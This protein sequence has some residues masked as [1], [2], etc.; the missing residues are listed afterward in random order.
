LQA[1]ALLHSEVTRQAQR[2]E[3]AT[4]RSSPVGAEER[5]RLGANGA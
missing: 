1:V 5:A 4:R 2:D 3:A